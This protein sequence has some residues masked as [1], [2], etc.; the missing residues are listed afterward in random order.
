MQPYI[1]RTTDYGKSWQR[2]D[3]GI[4]A[5]EF[6]RVVRE[7][8]VR[9]GLLYAGTERGVWVSFDD[10]A[11]WQKLQLNLPPVPVHDLAVKEGD[12]VAATH[13]RSFYI[14]DDVTPLRQMDARDPAPSH[15]FAP[16]AAVRLRPAGFTGTPL[17][18]DEPMASNP[19]EG[20]SIDYVLDG[21]AAG[22][23]VIRIADA[24]GHTVREY[25]SDDR[26][27]ATDLAKIRVAPEWTAPPSP[28][29]TTAGMHRF[30]WPIRYPAPAALAE[31]NPYA[32]G[33]WA[34]PG[35]YTVELTVGSQRRTQPLTIRPDPRVTMTPASYAQQFALARRVE[36]SS[37]RVA[38]AVTA[39]DAIHKRLAA[40][41]PSDLDLRVQALL[42]PDFGSAPAAP[43][44][45]GLTS[46]R[47]LA[48]KLARFREAV[49]GA[50]A[51]PSPDAE[52][53]VAQIE[54]AVEAALSAWTALQAQVPSAP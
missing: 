48:G 50:D 11:N 7:D 4:A 27:P 9:R 17:P 52:G 10:G 2:V 33:V 36:A 15:L 28:P 31:G 19:P 13:G 3:D 35:L 39:A 21:P 43:P 20:A 1:W 18:K 40:G 34:P 42:G 46:L 30:V 47:T 25:R 53:G 32:D 44:P 12:L 37:A 26:L 23:V 45:A 22:P 16:A 14:L 29:S 54:P 6:V 41:G 8:P 24:E 38:A 51:P 5:E 49:D